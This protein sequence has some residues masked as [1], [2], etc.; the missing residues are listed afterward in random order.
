MKW[1]N[2]FGHLRTIRTHRKW[3][4]HYCFKAGIPWR[5]IVH[6]LSKYSP[7]EF[8]ESVK[9]YDGKRSPIDVCKEKNGWSKAWQ[10][11]KHRNKHH[12]E[13]WTDNYDSGTSTIL[14]PRKYAVELLCDF[15]GA[16]RAYMGKDFSF[17]KEYEW[18]INKRDKLNFRVHPAISDFITEAL[19]PENIPN[20]NRKYLKRLYEGFVWEYERNVPPHLHYNNLFAR[21]K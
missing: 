9:Y 8:W 21:G 20:F 5:G 15:I 7:V 14:M 11:H 18:W 4:R 10:H 1:N 2:F 12:A 17:E 16:G 19:K 13:Y 3:V 6:D